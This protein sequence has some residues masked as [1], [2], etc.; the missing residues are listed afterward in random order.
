MFRASN[1][2]GNP[3]DSPP[4][5]PATVVPVK[6]PAERSK[7]AAGADEGFA[8]LVSSERAGAGAEV[9]EGFLVSGVGRTAPT[10]AIGGDNEWKKELPPRLKPE[11]ENYAAMYLSTCVRQAMQKNPG[12]M[13]R[14]VLALC[15]P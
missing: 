6:P 13:A 14:L 12:Q 4:I 7:A 8:S 10:L 9:R 2:T 15:S 11:A 5:Q 1:A 3:F